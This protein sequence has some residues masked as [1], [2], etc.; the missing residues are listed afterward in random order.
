MRGQLFG[1]L[2]G[3]LFDAVE[4]V[5]PESLEVLNP[6]VHGFELLGVK[7]I[8]TAL[9]GLLNFDD[10]DFSKHPEVLGNGGLG[11]PELK[12]DFCDIALGPDGEEIDDFSTSG[13]GDG[14][15]DVGSCGGSSHLGEV[16]SYIG[17][18]QGKKIR[19]WF[20]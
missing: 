12:D 17:I 13:L 7:P 8:E 14:V 9:P 5:G 2:F 19:V 1:F 10:A 15:E 18:C 3:N 11:E 4:L 6:V 20:V 16:Y